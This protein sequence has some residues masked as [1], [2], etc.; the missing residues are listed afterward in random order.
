MST[1]PHIRTMASIA[2]VSITAAGM[3][4]AAQAMTTTTAVDD[5]IDFVI[6][7]STDNVLDVLDNDIDLGGEI[8]T[9]IVNEPANGSV[10]VVSGGTQLSYTPN[11]TYCNDAI[12][13]APDTFTYQLS[14]GSEATVSVVVA[15]PYVLRDPAGFDTDGQPDNLTWYEARAYCRLTVGTDIAHSKCEQANPGAGPPSVSNGDSCPDIPT[16]LPGDSPTRCGRRQLEEMMRIAQAT[17]LDFWTGFRWFVRLCSENGA[18]CQLD[19][20]LTWVDGTPL[21]ESVANEPFRAFVSTFFVDGIEGEPE[22]CGLM[23]GAAGLQWMDC[24]CTGGANDGQPCD[25]SEDSC[26]DGTCLDSFGLPCTLCGCYGGGA[27]APPCDSDSDCGNNAVCVEGGEYGVDCIGAPFGLLRHER[28]DGS[29]LPVD[30]VLCDNPKLGFEVCGCD[31][32]NDCPEGFNSCGPGQTCSS[33][34]VCWPE[35]PGQEGD[36]CQF[37]N[38]CASGLSCDISCT[39]MQECG[40]TDDDNWPIYDPTRFGDHTCKPTKSAQLGDSDGDGFHDQEDGCPLDAARVTP[41]FCGCGVV[42][43]GDCDNNGVPDGCDLLHPGRLEDFSS[44]AAH[45]QLNGTAAQ[46]GGAVQLTEALQG[47]LGTVIFG[48]VSTMAIDRFT[49]TFDFFMGG[50]TGADGMGFALIDA[51]TTDNGVLFNESGGNQ[52]LAVS[53]DTYHGNAAGGNHAR[54][55]SYGT[56]LA[57]V[58]V[59]HP[60]DDST[61]QH[62]TFE[63]DSSGATLVLADANGNATTIFSDVP[64]PGWTAIKA[65]YGFGA[66]TGSVTNAHYVDNVHFTA[67]SLT[68]DCDQN[69]VPDPCDTD[70]DGDGVPD[71]C[72]A[73]AGFDDNADADGDGT[74]DGC[75]PCPADS[76]DD[77]DGD[78][79]CES[80]DICPGFDDNADADGDGVPDG[81][82]ACAGFDDNADA[83][84]DG[85]ADG[86]DP[87][88]ADNPDDTDGDSVCE[89]ADICPGFDDNADADADTVPDGCDACVGEDASGDSDADGVCDSDDVCAGFDDSID[90]DSNGIPDGCDVVPCG[91][92]GDC[93]DGDRDGIRDDN[94]LFWA[95]EAGACVETAIVFADMGGQFGVCAVDGTADGND[96]F[97]ALNCFAN[98]APDGGGDYPC[99]ASAPT[100]FNVDAGGQFGSCAPDGVCDGNDAFAALNAFGGSSSCSCPLDGAPAPVVDGG[101]AG[102]EIIDRVS[103]ELLARPV[104]GDLVEIDVFLTG[105]VSDLRGYQLHPTASA[106]ADPDRPVRRRSRGPRFCRR[107]VLGRVQPRDRPTGRGAR[108][109][110]YPCQE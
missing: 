33:T 105:G 76:P 53:L 22:Q 86:C 73:C 106:G 16:C 46:V 8:I 107:A 12:P 99:E 62:A 6:I 41:G 67:V 38:D 40:N 89:S 77:T 14:G 82:D 65:R 27:G 49:V 10:Q 80:A 108:H 32:P 21:Y 45:H 11:Q 7:N 84:G 93:A 103:I 101:G 71:G 39:T 98:T 23:N 102:V 55:R 92:H 70:S 83:D 69:G 3:H 63:L 79:V 56:T 85:T 42:E 44:P 59:P 9:M 13:S 52:P 78:S 66:R 47:Q 64:V 50:G 95:C 87:C 31:D 110:G 2:V 24:H 37:P 94:C 68:N 109:R 20:R 36:P 28:C 29:V 75:D 51:D 97:H 43:G 104:A 15:C 30:Y 88:P 60:L 54:L 4:P 96:R 19:E 1:K 90:E 57:D 61:W 26:P 34:N 18:G 81:C 58:L 35:G 25:G 72:D 74:A 48:P 100:A 5:H 91:T 17:R